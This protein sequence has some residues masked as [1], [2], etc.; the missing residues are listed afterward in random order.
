MTARADE[1]QDAA[2]GESSDGHVYRGE[3]QI[4][5]NAIQRLNVSDPE[6]PADHA[7]HGRIPRAARLA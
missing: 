3:T 1:N 4:R 6:Q 2:P 5:E 7:I